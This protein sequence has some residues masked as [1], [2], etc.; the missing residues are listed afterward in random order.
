M[1]VKTV[2][3]N[4]LV[5]RSYADDSKKTGYWYALNPNDVRG[6]GPRTGVFRTT[7]DL[8]LIDIQHENF[9]MNLKN[10]I[11][12]RIPMIAGLENSCHEILFPLGFDDVTFYRDLAK[13]YGVDSTN[14][15]LVPSVHTHSLLYF[16]NRSRLSIHEYDTVM[17]KFLK[18]VYGMQLDGI[19]SVTSFPDIIRNGMHLPELS[20]FDKS[21]IEYMHDYIHPLTGGSTTDGDIPIVY[22]VQT[23][24]LTPYA[25]E[26]IKLVNDVLDKLNETSYVD[27][28][29]VNMEE[30]AKQTPHKYALPPLRSTDLLPTTKRSSTRKSSRT[31]T[32]STP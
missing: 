2:P 7:K 3:K 16:N 6:Y 4:T 25:I 20:V 17:M 11:K 31:R 14:Y 24:D 12:Q 29:I 19:I 27:P 30:I 9:Y 13:M 22:P 26:R 32:K 5:Y 8:H 23:K 28:R 18:G 21:T 1:E 15:A 10:A